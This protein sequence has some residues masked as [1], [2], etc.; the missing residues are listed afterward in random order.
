MEALPDTIKTRFNAKLSRIDFKR[1]VAY[2]AQAEQRASSV[3]GQEHDDGAV[4][5][6]S[7]GE[8]RHSSKA[9]SG[10]VED[11][12][13]T[14]F[15]LIVGCD[16]SWSKVRNEMMR[17]ERSVTRLSAVP[18]FTEMPLQ[19]RLLSILHP[20]CVHRAAYARRSEETRRIRHRQESPTYLA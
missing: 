13:G 20:S 11:E 1:R 16:G 17:V 3:P 7:K 8:E 19:D 4:G 5:G 14:P 9:P 10:A 18:S 12:Q 2:G 6:G 15:D